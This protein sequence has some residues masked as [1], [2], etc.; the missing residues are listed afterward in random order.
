M[1]FCKLIT[2]NVVFLTLGACVT[3]Q[4]KELDY[5]SVQTGTKNI[6]MAYGVYTPP[7]W[8]PDEQLPIVLYL[9]GGNN[10][11]MS[12]EKVGA[13]KIF[14]R[15]M[16]SGS[17]PR[18]ILVTPDG[19]NFSLWENWADGSYNYRDWVM[20]SVLPKVQH[21]YNTLSCP[22]HCHLLGISMGGYGAMRF[23]LFEKAMFSS[24]SVLS[25]FIISNE[26]SE[27]AKGSFFLKLLF[28]IK[29]I[30]GKDYKARFHKENFY[31]TWPNDPELRKL[32]LQLIWGNNDRPKTKRANESFHQTL[33]EAG[34]E[35]D[36]FIYSG[37]HKWASW[38]PQLNKAMNFLLKDKNKFNEK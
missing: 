9:H 26:K 4:G 29:R 36:H 31:N 21:D 35:H 18:A 33:L 13:H 24:V 12:F 6:S 19:D 38:L 23:A 15:D 27:R 3:F 30:F 16:S 14:D 25:A 28:P 37:K 22:E 10:N 32:R 5:S 34:V 2:L 20:Q 1:K 7:H 17:I 11:H 8:T